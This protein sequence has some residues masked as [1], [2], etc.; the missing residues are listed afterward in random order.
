MGLGPLKAASRRWPLSAVPRSQRMHSAFT[1][2]VPHTEGQQY[3]PP[4][5]PPICLRV[6]QGTAVIQSQYSR[7]CST[8]RALDGHVTESRIQ[9]SRRVASGRD[10]YAARPRQP[11]CVPAL[12]SLVC[13]FPG[14]LFFGYRAGV[15]FFGY[16]AGPNALLSKR[17]HECTSWQNEKDQCTR[18]LVRVGQLRD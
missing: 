12:C 2:L 1:N 17:Y 18:Q 10:Y 4:P 6:V 7:A 16:R 3:Q 8:S 13:T 11:G 5:P 14:V 9:G 15:L